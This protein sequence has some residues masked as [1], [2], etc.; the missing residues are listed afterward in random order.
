M[1]IGPG[2]SLCDTIQPGVQYPV[3]ISEVCT[4]SRPQ[5]SLSSVPTVIAE[6]GSLVRSSLV[7]VS[8]M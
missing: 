7:D 3:L 2:I 5:Y 8:P 4:I 6:R 1:M